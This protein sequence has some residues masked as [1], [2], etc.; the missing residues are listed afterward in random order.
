MKIDG[1]N[2]YPYLPLPVD[3]PA[4]LQQ[5]QLDV[6]QE[7]TEEHVEDKSRELVAQQAGAHA[8]SQTQHNSFVD[9]TQQARNDLLLAKKP[10]VATKRGMKR[11]L[12]T[13]QELRDPGQG[14]LTS[15][16]QME[17]NRQDSPLNPRASGASEGQV[18]QHLLQAQVGGS[19]QDM[20]IRVSRRPVM[21]ASVQAAQKLMQGEASAPLEDSTKST[22][23]EPVA[24]SHVK[25]IEPASTT[26]E[27]ESRVHQLSDS[28]KASWND[29]D[30]VA[31]DWKQ[32]HQLLSELKPG[33]AKVV[34]PKLDSMQ[35][36]L[37]LEGLEHSSAGLSTQD[38][39]LAYEKVAR[40]ASPGQL[41]SSLE[42]IAD[43]GNRESEQG[44]AGFGKAVGQYA[45]TDAIMSFVEQARSGLSEGDNRGVAMSYAMAGLRQEP[46]KLQQLMDGFSSGQLRALVQQASG[47]NVSVSMNPE[48]GATVTTSYHAEPL[49][50]LLGA[51]KGLPTS[52]SKAQLAQYSN[53]ILD[54]IANTVSTPEHLIVKNN[55]LE[56]LQ[57]SLL[58]W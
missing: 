50:E 3:T 4:V 5:G 41:S 30:V 15:G 22:E 35:M 20:P 26:F 33:E 42:H 44:V 38:K 13:N 28:L 29:N 24:P 14:P 2:P 45:S 40:F 51:A 18:G 37:Y 52:S 11:S 46:E 48:A 36:G 49:A 58:G 17:G 55:S 34:L 8:F 31:V 1:A 12:A 19:G 23:R 25:P 7:V 9:A 6:K 32:S 16:F 39:S 54:E 56:L 21:R 47:K 53:Q 10:T 43:R 27:V 57:N